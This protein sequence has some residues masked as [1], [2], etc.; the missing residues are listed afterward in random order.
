[1]PGTPGRPSFSAHVRFGERGALVQGWKAGRTGEFLWGYRLI[2]HGYPKSIMTLSLSPFALQR[3]VRSKYDE[4]AHG[5][6]GDEDTTRRVWRKSL[7]DDQNRMY[8]I[9]LGR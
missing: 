2:D 6:T 8:E 1:V 5:Q 4:P 3:R 7:F 9:T